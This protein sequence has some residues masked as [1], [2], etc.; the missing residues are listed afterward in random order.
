M[1]N[2]TSLEA[3]IVRRGA[4]CEPWPSFVEAKMKIPCRR[5]LAT[6]PV[7]F[8]LVS[9]S[10][11]PQ[12]RVELSTDAGDVGD[13]DPRDDPSQPPQALV[14]AIAAAAERCLLEFG[15][16]VLNDIDP[17]YVAQRRDDAVEN[18]LAALRRAAGVPGVT[19]DAARVSACITDLATPTCEP[20]DGFA[21]RALELLN[22]CRADVLVTGDAPPGAPCVAGAQCASGECTDACVC[23]ARQRPAPADVDDRSRLACL[24][25]FGCERGER[26]ALEGV[27]GLTEVTASCVPACG[28]STD[29]AAGEQCFD[30]ACLAAR[31]E[32]ESCFLTDRRFTCAD[33]LSC[34]DGA[35]RSA[36]AAA[37]D[38]CEFDC[39]DDPSLYCDFAASACAA[40]VGVGG[41]CAEAACGVGLACVDDV[42]V[43]PPELDQPCFFDE[44]SGSE[45]G[46][47]LRCEHDA[48]LCRPQLALGERC[49]FDDRDCESGSCDFETELCLPAVPPSEGEACLPG[50]PCAD[51]LV[52]ALEAGGAVCRPRVVGRALGEACT[53]GQP[54]ICPYGQVCGAG[55]TCEALAIVEEGTCAPFS[56]AFALLQGPAC[57]AGLTTRRC[58]VEPGE[59]SGLC[60]ARGDAG[61][62][63]VGDDECVEGTQC[64]SGTCFPRR[65]AGQTCG[66][67]LPACLPRLSCVSGTCLAADQVPPPSCPP[68]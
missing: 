28:R 31:A 10:A 29:C 52:C 20:R 38:F 45:C 17:A 43:P 9:M 34:F 58:A 23:T 49:A 33:G 46:A 42:C 16:G 41:V 61:A 24:D 15:D 7:M 32:G 39:G 63:C 26:C 64:T 59:S 55:G 37:G 66:G 44:R 12:R 36:P 14:D 13:D 51:G 21:P 57:A 68:L 30:G 56:P 67:A 11:C 8:L 18:A 65:A 4:P 50:A 27:L 54:R 25:D 22:E 40:R 47:G 2:V 1:T 48:G 5:A 62:A 53:P 35:C 60:A 19:F 6:L 3:A